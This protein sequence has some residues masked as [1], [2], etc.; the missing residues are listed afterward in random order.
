M[1]IKIN[2]LLLDN[3]IERV[4]RAIDPNPFLPIMKGILIEAE[5]NQ[6]TLIGS[7]GELSI[8]HVIKVSADA[9]IITPGKAVVEL[10]IF[11]NIIKKLD[12]DLSIS[13]DDK[14]M[15]IATDYDRYTLNLYQTSEFPEIDF[16]IFGDTLKISWDELKKMTRNVLFAASN[17][18]INL[19]L[20]CVNI[21]CSNNV[22]K[23]IATDRYRFAQETKQ[24]E[25]LNDF[26]VSI[27]AKNL[28]DIFTFD[29]NGEVTLFISRYKVAFELEGTII[30][31]KVIDQVYQDVSRVIPKEF[32]TKLVIE[33][34]ELSNLLNKASVI[35]SESYNKMRL[36]VD[37]DTLIFSSTR[38]E[39]ANA[40]IKTKNFQYNEDELK[41]SINSKYLKDA[42]SVFDDIIN[43]NITKD[44]LR[45]V[46]TSDSNPNN[47][48]LFTPNKGF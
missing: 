26:N 45:I 16:S 37:H 22:L 6:I 32:A 36:H 44:K 12:N 25:N 43:L 9:E 4:N 35:T 24:V 30:Q 8:K 11:R 17:N 2:K 48:Q 34:R 42:I 41:L 1:E 40:E 19:V 23:F 46:V 5:D 3:A 7:N 39:I 15:L 27:V 20:C 33:K 38:D 31:T 21:S 14:T 10:S 28:K 13:S 47:L 29:F 18:E